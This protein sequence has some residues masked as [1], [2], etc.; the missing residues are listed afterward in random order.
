MLQKFVKTFG[1]DPNK[2]EIEKTTEI[3]AQVNA[4]EADFEKLSDDELRAKTDVF[5]AHISAAVPPPAPPP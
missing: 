1:G 2:K 5:R 4:L 3:V